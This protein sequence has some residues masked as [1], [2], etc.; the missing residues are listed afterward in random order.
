MKYLWEISLRNIFVFSCAD[1]SPLHLG[2][3]SSIGTWSTPTTKHHYCTFT[4]T[5]MIK[6]MVRIYILYTG[7]IEKIFTF[8]RQDVNN[9]IPLVKTDQ[10]HGRFCCCFKNL[11]IVVVSRIT[12]ALLS[13]VERSSL[14]LP[15][16]SSQHAS[17]FTESHHSPPQDDSFSLMQ[18][19]DKR[20]STTW[21]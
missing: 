17:L 4:C 18:N 11:Y 1:K 13:C 8:W 20:V 10:I 19:D 7:N 3:C 5:I 14:G 9:Y 16:I 2:T 12:E 21:G 15:F 6:P